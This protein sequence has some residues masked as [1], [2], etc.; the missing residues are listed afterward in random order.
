MKTRDSKVTKMAALFDKR[1]VW[2]VDDLAPA[3]GMRADRKPLY[4]ALAIL[5]RRKIIS[6]VAYGVYEKIVT[7]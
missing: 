2:H 1:R 3:M 5:R 4:N 7:D 6:R